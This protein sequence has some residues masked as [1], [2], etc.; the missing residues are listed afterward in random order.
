MVCACVCILTSAE[1][2][3]THWGLTLYRSV[4]TN[5]LSLK[6]KTKTDGGNLE[7]PNKHQINWSKEKCKEIGTRGAHSYLGSSAWKSSGVSQ[8]QSL[9]V[10]NGP[11]RGFSEPEAHS[12][13][14][15][16]LCSCHSKTWR[17]HL[18]QLGGP[19]EIKLELSAYLV[20]GTISQLNKPMSMNFCVHQKTNQAIFHRSLL[21]PVSYG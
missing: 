14:R 17:Y 6:T 7:N 4:V 2:Q 20:R 10:W 13:P 11:W 18:G 1:N 3:N 8:R 19:S 15:G 16:K 5:F 9:L 21:E 12:I